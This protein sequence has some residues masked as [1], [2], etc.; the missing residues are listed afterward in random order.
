MTEE[1]TLNGQT[2]RIDREE[3][4]EM[5][6]LLDAGGADRCKC[7]YCAYFSEHRNIAYSKD[8]VAMLSN[9]GI[10]YTKEDE[11]WTVSQGDDGEPMQF[12]GW[13]YVAGEFE[14]PASTAANSTPPM[15]PSF[16]LASESPPRLRLEFAC[17]ILPPMPPGFLSGYPRK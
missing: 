17:E 1:F 12:Y 16:K 3:T 14:R 5:Y 9:F 10:D 8:F 6:R 11:V 4:K 15:F 7:G 13:F 2:I